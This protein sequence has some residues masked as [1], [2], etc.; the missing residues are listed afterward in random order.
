MDWLTDIEM[1][2]S[3]C[4]L[5]SR[6]ERLIYVGISV[7]NIITPSVSTNSAHAVK[8]DWEIFSS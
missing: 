6:K 5:S 8:S 3:W 2:H 7:E 1:K 4:D